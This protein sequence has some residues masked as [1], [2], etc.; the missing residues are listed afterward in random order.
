MRQLRKPEKQ[1]VTQITIGLLEDDLAYLTQR[2][3]E[4]M[5]DL[6]SEILFRLL[7]SKYDILPASHMQAMRERVLS[8]MQEFKNSG[9][10]E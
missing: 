4:N 3:S 7:Q 1:A 5:R 10:G 6:Q 9:A 2:A 8:V